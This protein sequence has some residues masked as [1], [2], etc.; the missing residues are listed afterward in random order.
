M[1]AVELAVEARLFNE[2]N[3]NGYS[4]LVSTSLLFPSHLQAGYHVNYVP[5]GSWVHCGEV[6]KATWSGELSGKCT[7]AA[8]IYVWNKE[9]HINVRLN[10]TVRLITL[11]KIQWCGFKNSK[12]KILQDWAIVCWH[13][14]AGEWHR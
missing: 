11:Q 7:C 3:H 8:V 14:E 12:G 1:E 2:N 4:I 10:Q 6:L 5:D 13:D 9:L